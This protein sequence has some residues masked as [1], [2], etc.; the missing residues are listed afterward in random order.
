MGGSRDAAR[1]RV[2]IDGVAIDNLTMEEAVQ[3]VEGHIDRASGLLVV[4]P[5]VDHLLRL[6]RD[7]E[8]RRA[9][10]RAG[11]VLADGMPLLWLARLQGTP[12]KAKVSGSDFLIEFCRIAS[13]RGRRVFFLGSAEGVVQQAAR[14][15]QERYP[16]LVVAGTYSPTWGF[17][18]NEEET[19]RILEAVKQH[20]PDILFVGAGA[21]KQEKWLLHHWAELSP[22][23]CVGVGA[24]FDFISGR[25]RRA[26]R[27]MRQAGLEWFWRLIHEPLRLF[28]RYILEDL[29]FLCYLAVKTLGRRLKGIDS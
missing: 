12:L 29:P 16:G 18:R 10:A 5:N 19:R 14:I 22:T 26:P 6:R 13:V 21:P 7:E 28:H 8:F 25:V 1:E 2:V 9:Y 24:A 3:V 23:V 27:W 17:D 15:L 20:E 4:T 11:L